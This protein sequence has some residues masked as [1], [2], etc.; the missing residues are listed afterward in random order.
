MC[1]NKDTE[2]YCRHIYLEY[3]PML[4]RFAEKFVSSFFAEDIVHDV[5]LKLWDRQVFLLPEN[6]LKRL[7]YVS[8]RNAC[9]D[10]LRRLTLEQEVVDKRALQLK[11]D[12][13]DFFE[14]SDEVFMRKDLLD[15]LMRKVDDLPER[16]REIFRLSYIEGM[17]NA[18]IADKLGL[19]VRTVENQ[20]YRSLSYLRKQFPNLRFMLLILLIHNCE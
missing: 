13:L 15:I 7:L 1:T 4:L 9:V 11:L 3:A 19:S 8:V 5:F 14:A 20:L 6:E 2:V 10:Y 16:S 12:E 18:E 17:R